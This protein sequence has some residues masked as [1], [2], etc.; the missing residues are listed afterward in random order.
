MALHDIAESTP[1]ATDRPLLTDD[2]VEFGVPAQLVKRSEGPVPALCINL[3][4]DS[5]CVNLDSDCEFETEIGTDKAEAEVSFDADA[6]NP[7]FFRVTHTGLGKKKH[8]EKGCLTTHDLGI[9]IIPVAH[10]R[11]GC[12]HDKIYVLDLSTTSS[13]FGFGVPKLATWMSEARVSFDKLVQHWRSWTPLSPQLLGVRL[14][15]C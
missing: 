7:V 3:D 11:H 14:V 1:S 13:L 2:C 12:Q 9:Q 6:D 5:E 8:V 15:A 4:V 10:V